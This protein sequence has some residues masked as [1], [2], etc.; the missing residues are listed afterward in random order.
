MV[1][2]Y[3]RQPVD[4]FFCI[5]TDN[6]VLCLFQIINHFPR[7]DTGFQAQK[8]RSSIT[9]IQNIIALILSIMYSELP[10]NELGGRMDLKTEITATYG[11]EKIKANRKILAKPGFNRFSEQFFAFQQYQIHSRNFKIH[12]SYIKI[13]TVFFRHTIKTP[14]E[15]LFMPVKITYFFHPLSTPRCRVEKRDYPERSLDCLFDS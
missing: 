10:V 1:V 3:C 14:S 12:F 13:K 7:I 15:I 11:I 9:G 4:I 8:H 6:T 5:E 2:F